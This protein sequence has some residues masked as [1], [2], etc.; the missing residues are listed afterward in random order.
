[1]QRRSPLSGACGGRLGARGHVG[2]G[3]VG[4]RQNSELVGSI[5]VPSARHRAGSDAAARAP[6]APIATDD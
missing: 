2:R 3:P 4:G 1:M 5:I 6:H